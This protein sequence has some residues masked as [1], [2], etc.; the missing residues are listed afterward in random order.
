MYIEAKTQPGLNEYVRISEGIGEKAYMDVQYLVL[1]KGEEWIFEESEKE[2]AI[3]L[4]DGDVVFEA[5]GKSM[6]AVRKNMFE[7]NPYC[8]HI[9]VQTKATI[10]ANSHSELYIQKAINSNKFEP[11]FYEPKDVHVHELATNGELDG[12]IQRACRTIFDYDNAPYSKMVLGEILHT[13]GKWSSYPPHA[14][15]QPEVYFYRFTK[16][17]GF[18]LGLADG[19]A[20]RTGHNGLAVITEGAHCQVVAPGYNLCYVWGIYHLDDNPWLKTRIYEEEHLWLVDGKDLF[21]S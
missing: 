9:S 15:P 18:G 13:P 3:I 6:P 4:F 10:R 20:Y 12:C 21:K 11:V 7:E 16:P 5:N 19:E 14:H 8:L 2:V 1:G 17:Q